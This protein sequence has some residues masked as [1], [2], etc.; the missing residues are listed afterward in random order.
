MIW[1]LVILILCITVLFQ[2]NRQ[3]FAVALIASFTPIVHDLLFGGVEGVDYF[4]S[5]SLACLVAV[6]LV[7]VVNPVSWTALSIQRIFLGMIGLNI[8]GAFI[9]WHGYNPAIYANLFYCAYAFAAVVLLTRD[10]ADVGGHGVD[11]GGF[12]IHRYCG[13]WLRS[14][15]ENKGKI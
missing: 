1:E 12:E 13:V 3:R 14:L 2:P 9:Y 8:L 7:G 5:A 11:R 4:T 6:I 15:P 10:R